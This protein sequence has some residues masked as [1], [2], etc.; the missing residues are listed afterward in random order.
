MKTFYLMS[1]WYKCTKKKQAILT[2]YL[3]K[4]NKKDKINL[5]I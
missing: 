2:D 4:F 5:K 1:L 3:S